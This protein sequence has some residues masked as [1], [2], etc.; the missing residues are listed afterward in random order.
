MALKDF[1]AGYKWVENQLQTRLRGYAQ[2]WLETPGG[3]LYNE[4][5]KVH[6]WVMRAHFFLPDSFSPSQSRTTNVRYQN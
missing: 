4:K 6:R 1:E 3:L 5:Y 2:L